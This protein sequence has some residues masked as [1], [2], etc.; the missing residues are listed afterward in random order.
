MPTKSNSQIS[1]LGD[2]SQSRNEQRPNQGPARHEQGHIHA[3][4]QGDN[5]QRMGRLG[6]TSV[7]RRPYQADQENRR[8]EGKGFYTLD[9]ESIATIREDFANENETLVDGHSKEIAQLLDE[10]G[11]SQI[12]SSLELET[13]EAEQKRRRARNHCAPR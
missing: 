6:T 7:E 12:Q 3:S 8:K 2:E 13:Y 10:F 5:A 11:D 4:N 9:E 1:H